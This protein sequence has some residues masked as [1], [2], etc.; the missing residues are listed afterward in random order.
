MPIR[1]THSIGYT[2]LVGIGALFFRYTLLKNF[3]KETPLWLF[4][5]LPFSHLVLDF[6]VGVH[7]NP[8][9]FPFSSEVFV[10]PL[11]ILP[12]SGRID[13]SNYYFWRNLGIELAIFVPIVFL[14]Q[15]RLR[16]IL[17]RE[18]VLMVV[19]LALFI[20]GI[21]IGISLDR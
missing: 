19:L 1:Y 7:G 9:L 3:L 8:Y 6:L 13:L 12:S 21:F 11:G 15:K 18:K 17:L 20:L 16:G 2:F 14:L 10:S 4:F 5:L